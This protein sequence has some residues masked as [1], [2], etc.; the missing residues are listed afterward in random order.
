VEKNSFSLIVEL[1]TQIQ[2]LY[3]QL[4]AKNSQVKD[5]NED[6]HKQAVHI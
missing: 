3:E 5:Q 1:K 2:T 4:R 6:M